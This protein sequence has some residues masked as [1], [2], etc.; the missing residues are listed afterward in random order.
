MLQ[1]IEQRDEEEMKRTNGWTKER[2]QLE[3]KL[4]DVTEQ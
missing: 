1:E 4:R 3:Q 2:E